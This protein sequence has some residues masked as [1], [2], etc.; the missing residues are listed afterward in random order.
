MDRI[1]SQTPVT[2]YEVVAPE[3]VKNFAE[4]KIGSALALEQDQYEFVYNTNRFGFANA[5]QIV[6]QFGKRA[7]RTGD[8]FFPW[9]E[10]AARFAEDWCA[11]L[12][13]LA[14]AALVFPVVFVLGTAVYCIIKR[15]TVASFAAKY[16]KKLFKMELNSNKEEEYQ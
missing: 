15:R 12:A 2:C 16:I 1:G 11:L 10:N 6:S 9:W 4:E 13:L 7:Q 8:I 5:L 14:C 3:P